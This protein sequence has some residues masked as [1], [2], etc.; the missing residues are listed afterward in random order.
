MI[1]ADV[2]KGPAQ[3]FLLLN[4]LLDLRTVKFY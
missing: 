2:G 4:Y 1:G 3:G